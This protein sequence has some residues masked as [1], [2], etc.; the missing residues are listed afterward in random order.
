MS[1][2]VYTIAAAGIYDLICSE[3]LLAVKNTTFTRL[4]ALCAK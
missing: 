4:F 3:F 1:N 2:Y